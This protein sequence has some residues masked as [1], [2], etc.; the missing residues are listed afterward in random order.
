MN[1]EAKKF[2]ASTL[3]GFSIIGTTVVLNPIIAEGDTKITIQ[4]L[5]TKNPSSQDKLKEGDRLRF[6][7]ESNTGS[8][9]DVYFDEQI[10]KNGESK[11]GA[12]GAYFSGKSI[13]IE[14]TTEALFLSPGKHTITVYENLNRK[15]PTIETFE[16]AEKTEPEN[17][18]NLWQRFLSIFH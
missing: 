2:I 8:R 14:D 1:I 16:I 11:N 4:N 18:T 3:V 6:L 10:D 17:H 15:E 12:Y 9:H 5:N 13:E 7:I